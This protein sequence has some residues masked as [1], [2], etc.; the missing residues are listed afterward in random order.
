[1]FTQLFPIQSLAFF[2]PHIFCTSASSFPS[3][4]A[5]QPQENILKWW[6]SPESSFCL[7]NGRNFPGKLPSVVFRS[8]CLESSF[9]PKFKEEAQFSAFCFWAAQ[10]SAFCFWGASLQIKNLVLTS[11][12]S[13]AACFWQLLLPL[14]L[15]SRF[16][17][18]VWLLEI[19]FPY[20]LNK[21]INK[22]IFSWGTTKELRL[23]FVV[24]ITLEKNLPVFKIFNSGIVNKI[25]SHLSFCYTKFYEIIILGSDKTWL[26]ISLRYNNYGFR[27][28]LRKYSNMP[29]LFKYMYK[30][31]FGI[32]LSLNTYLFSR[33]YHCYYCWQFE[34]SKNHSQLP[35]I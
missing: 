31:M 18:Q 35:I 3:Q 27:T 19:V 25:L 17:S 8:I 34:V 22:K 9:L 10:F 28:S 30:P 4:K 29:H 15:R 12:T 13:S 33:S 7:N 23:K 11:V 20:I 24:N 2:S 6:A 32:S 5:A 14:P 26:N 16:S 1:M 21:G